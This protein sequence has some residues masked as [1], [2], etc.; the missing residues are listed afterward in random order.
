MDGA[1]PEE[2][3]RQGGVP[4]AFDRLRQAVRNLLSSL[5]ELGRRRH[6]ALAATITDLNAGDV[7]GIVRTAKE[8]GADIP[9]VFEAQCLRDLPLPFDAERDAVSLRAH[10]VFRDGKR[11]APR[12]ID[13]SNAYLDSCRRRFSAKRPAANALP[14][15]RISS[16]TRARTSTRATIFPGWR[17]RSRT[18]EGGACGSPGA[19]MRM[20]PRGGS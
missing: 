18:W 11:G 7:A 12:F 3:D 10:E 20:L 15:A 8:L 2:H 19:R 14:P 17:S 5:S 6:C 9:S 4:E 16:S 13:N 1:A